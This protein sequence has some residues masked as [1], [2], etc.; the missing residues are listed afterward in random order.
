VS[1]SFLRRCLLVIAIVGGISV[2]PA[3]AISLYVGYYMLVPRYSAVVD[4]DKLGFNLRLDLY[5]TGDEAR[6]SGRYLSVINGGSYHTV[7]LKGWSWSHRARTG[8]YMIDANHLAVLSA[9]GNDYEIALKP[10]DFKPIDSGS[11]EQWQYLGA[12][13]FFFPPGKPPRLQFFDQ[14]LAECIPMG[15]IEPDKWVGEPRAQVRRANC[16]TPR[17]EEGVE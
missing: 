12:F 4:F 1:Q 3:A 9:L 14:R 16:P 11:G 15:T 13:D 5:L 8:V 6:D 2:I 7:M 10:F 17:S